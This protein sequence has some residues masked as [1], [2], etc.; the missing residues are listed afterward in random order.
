VRSLA[1]S[2]GAVRDSD[3]QLEYLDAQ[4]HKFTADAES[5][6]PL[7][8]RISGERSRA[9]ARL[10]R[11][12]DSP[13]VRAW[14]ESWLANLRDPDAITVR[15]TRLTGRVAHDVIRKQ[16]RKLRK[17]ADTLN[18][19]SQA[20]AFH[21]VR[22]HTKRLR[23]LVEAFEGLYGP[24]AQDYHRALAKLQDVLGAFQD[25]VV[26]EQRFTELVSGAALP[27][28]TSFAVGRLVERDADAF[29]KCREKFA[30]AYRRTRKRRWRALETAMRRQADAGSTA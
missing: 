12:L 30:K 9:R 6:V 17:R 11:E 28:R 15:D 3:V 5:L 19:K 26:R 10:L 13:P 14:H 21:R 1:K 2:L 8:E 4:R 29:A 27:A 16:A 22:A 7:R 20:Q 25:A 23:Y 24:A 18:A